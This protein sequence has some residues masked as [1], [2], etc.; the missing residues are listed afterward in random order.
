MVDSVSEVEMAPFSLQ[1]FYDISEGM[2]RNV[3]IPR[4]PVDL[5]ETF[6]L[7]PLFFIQLVPHPLNEIFDGDK[8]V[9]HARLCE[10]LSI[11]VMPPFVQSTRNIHLVR[12]HYILHVQRK[13]VTRQLGEIHVNVDVQPVILV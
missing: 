3:E 12:S 6:H 5:E 4:H 8:A 13:D 7:T 9:Q 11:S 1:C 2:V 10:E